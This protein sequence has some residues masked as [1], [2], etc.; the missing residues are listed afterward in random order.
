MVDNGAALQFVAAAE[1][2][3]EVSVPY[4]V[5]DGSTEGTVQ[6]T[7]TVTVIGADDDGQPPVA[8]VDN[9]T[10]QVGMTVVLDVL[11]ND[12]DPDGDA[13][14]VQSFDATCDDGRVVWQPGGRVAYTAPA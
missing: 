12:W 1:A 5:S 13:L 3:G 6:R 14:V 11:A 7:A 8:V 9:S 2:G 10:V 4:T